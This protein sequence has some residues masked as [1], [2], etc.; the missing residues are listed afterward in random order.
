MDF[1]RSAI[2][3][4]NTPTIARING[5]QEAEQLLALRTAEPS[6]EFEQAFARVLRDFADSILGK[7]QYELRV[8]TEAESVAFEKSQIGF[9]IHNGQRYD[10]IPIEYLTWLA[11][12][13]L[14]LSAYLRSERGRARIEA[15]S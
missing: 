4:E 11:D 7:P 13:S 3:N 6:P 9:G 8:M 5:R 1:D 12:K 15:A 2:L 14:E 10:S